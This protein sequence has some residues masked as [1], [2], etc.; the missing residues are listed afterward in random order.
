MTTT[1]P[2]FEARREREIEDTVARIMRLMVDMTVEEK[3]RVVTEIDRLVA[4]EESTH[5]VAS[6]QQH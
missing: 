6:G 1:N 2:E 4:Y 5:A 3:R